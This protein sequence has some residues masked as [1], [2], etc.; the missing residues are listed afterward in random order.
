VWR[1]CPCFVVDLAPLTLPLCFTRVKYFT[2][3]G[4][5]SYGT[6]LFPRAAFLTG[7][8]L[9]G[10]VFVLQ[11]SPVSIPEKTVIVKSFIKSGVLLSA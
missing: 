2:S 6:F 5:F 10:G 4:S 3:Q 1:A 7:K 8:A 9:H 11:D